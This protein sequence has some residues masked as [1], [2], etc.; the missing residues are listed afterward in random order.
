LLVR[1]LSLLAAALVVVILGGVAAS[2]AADAITSPPTTQDVNELCEYRVDASGLNF[3]EAP[4]I[5]A[6]I[7]YR[8]GRN[9]TFYATDEVWDN[10]YD[11]YHWR[12]TG[13]DTYA[14]NE[15]MERTGT[16]CRPL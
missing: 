5:N 12:R 6:P 15:Y 7:E 13:R 16:P 11:P 14:A 3:R 2:A 9:Q 10:A 1:K 4:G 8:L